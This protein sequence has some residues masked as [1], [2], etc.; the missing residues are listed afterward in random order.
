[1][2]LPRVSSL[3]NCARLFYLASGATEKTFPTNGQQKSLDTWSG[4]GE[5]P[6]S[7]EKGLSER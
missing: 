6:R 2:T 3:P 1:M 7:V 5:N 4:R